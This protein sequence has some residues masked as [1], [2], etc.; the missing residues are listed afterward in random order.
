M[1]EKPGS[2]SGRADRPDSPAHSRQ[3]QR[4]RRAARRTGVSPD[5]P[6]PATSEGRSQPFSPETPYSTARCT[7]R[8]PRPARRRS[9]SYSILRRSEAAPTVSAGMALRVTFQS[10]RASASV[11]P[12]CPWNVTVT[13]SP[14]VACPNTGTGL[15]R[16]QHH[17]V[18]EEPPRPSPP[19]AQR[20]TSAPFPSARSGSAATGFALRLGRSMF[21]SGQGFFAVLHALRDLF[22]RVGVGG[23]LVLQLD[24]PVDRATSPFSTAAAPL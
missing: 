12:D 18:G 15:P 3:D 5:S 22:H 7:A 24:I 11:D 13:F 19:P 2:G 10:P 9:G 21:G 23:N 16:C 20:Q 1:A 4:R 8:H 14:G 17:V 6:P